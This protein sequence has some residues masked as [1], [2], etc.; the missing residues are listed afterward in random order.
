MIEKLPL[1][2]VRN[3]YDILTNGNEDVNFCCL[4]FHN[5][6]R[7]AAVSNP[8]AF[9]LNLLKLNVFCRI[10]FLKDKVFSEKIGQSHLSSVFVRPA[11]AELASGM[12]DNSAIITDIFDSAVTSL[13]TDKEIFEMI[14]AE[15][16]VR[17]FAALRQN[18][19][20]K[21]VKLE[22]IYGKINDALHSSIDYNTELSYRR[23]FYVPNRYVVRL[24]DIAAFNNLK[25]YAYVTSSLPR[26][27]IEAV[28]QDYSIPFDVL[29]I[30]VEE[31]FKIEAPQSPKSTGVLSSDYSFI[32]KFK[33]YGCKPFYYRNP[34]L[35]MNKTV[36]PKLSGEFRKAYD[37]VC[38]R[39]LFSGM[40]RYSREYELA[41][42]CLAPAVYGSEQSEKCVNTYFEASTAEALSAEKI[43]ASSSV[44]M[45]KAIK[46]FSDDITQY[47]IQTCSKLKI[48][49][50][51]A[52]ALFKQ[53]EQFLI[54]IVS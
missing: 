6:N 32:K 16:G 20:D 30:S 27:F 17:G 24:L 48:S 33:K 36:H 51:D 3:L 29:S 25:I 13:K 42:L 12:L 19:D 7:E 23:Q 26:T 11:V 34:V 39:R 54:S 45:K 22:V 5:Q 4:C 37:T 38:G 46:D 28:M 35:V 47:F 40:N 31:D 44:E 9:G 1:D 52:L 10:P 14:E 41:Y 49:V 43:M 53:G 15:T 2:F 18:L 50:S 8:V 21:S